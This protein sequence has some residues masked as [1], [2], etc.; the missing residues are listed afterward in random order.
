MIF[1][2]GPKDGETEASFLE[3]LAHL[4]FRQN[5]V[6]VFDDIRLMKMVHLWRGI[7]HPKMDLTS[8]GHWSGTGLVDWQPSKTL[9]SAMDKSIEPVHLQP[10]QSPAALASAPDPTAV[11]LPPDPVPKNHGT[12]RILMLCHEKPNYIPD[13]LLHGLR[14][15]L[16]EAVVDYPEKTRRTMDVSANPIW[17]KSEPDGA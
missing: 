12:T 10:S 14:K 17:K 16:G 1:V 7:Q 2:D 5:P 15:L 11:R 4:P 6:I 3:Q 8:F 9:V 13:L